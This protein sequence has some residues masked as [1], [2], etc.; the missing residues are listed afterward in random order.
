LSLARAYKAQDKTDQAL[1]IT[2]SILQQQPDQVNTLM[3]EYELLQKKG[4]SVNATRALEKA[5]ILAPD[6]REINYKLAYQYAEAKDPKAITLTDTLIA[7]D[8]LKLFA[9]PYYIRG[10]YYSNIKDRTKA[11]QWFNE[12][13]RQHYNY[14][15]AYI[16]KGKVLLDQKQTSEALKTFQLALTID[17]TFA[18]AWYWTGRCHEHMGQKEEAKLNYEKAYGLDKTFIEAKEAADA[19]K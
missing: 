1:A 4:D 14:L 8:S 2:R 16:E 17:P 10:L 6:N 12:T 9:E 7:K 19:I 5:R 3:L 11:I 13:I 15:N 18:D